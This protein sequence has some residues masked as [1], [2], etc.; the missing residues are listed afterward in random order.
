M[1]NWAENGNT[2]TDGR[3]AQAWNALSPK[4][5]AAK[6]AVPQA[7]REDPRF[8]TNE[9]RFA[10][11]AEINAEIGRVTRTRPVAHWIEVL[12]AAGV[13]CGEVLDVARGLR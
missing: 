10:R 3:F 12:N 11:R 4:L 1:E 7:L 13:P 5:A 6:N 2:G 8:A 9:A